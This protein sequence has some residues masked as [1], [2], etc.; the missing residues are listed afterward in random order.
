MIILAFKQILN[1]Y[2]IK[3]LLLI[4]IYEQKFDLVRVFRD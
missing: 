1:Y 4:M 3:N 2:S